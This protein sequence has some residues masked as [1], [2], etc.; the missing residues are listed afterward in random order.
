MIAISDTDHVSLVAI[1]AL[2]GRLSRK[3]LFKKLRL[4]PLSAAAVVQ[5][6]AL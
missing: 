6:H 5:I 1:G 4:I 3:G 2:A